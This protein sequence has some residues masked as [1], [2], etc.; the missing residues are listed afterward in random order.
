MK[1]LIAVISAGILLGG[2]HVF[3]GDKNGPLEVR[4]PAVADVVKKLP[5]LELPEVRVPPPSRDDVIA[6]YQRVYGSVPDARENQAVGKRLADLEMQVGEDRD[7]A[8]E[9]APYQAAIQLYEELLEQPNGQDVDQIIYQLARAYDVVGDN[10]S[11]KKYLDRLITQYPESAYAVESRF[12]RA[13]MAFS[14]EQY[15]T[16]AEDYSFVVEHGA[17][18]SY[19]QNANYM[20][21][22]CRFKESQLDLSLD[23][24]F[25]VVNSITPDDAEPDR[26]AQELLDDVLRVIVLAVSYLD[27]PKTLADHMDQLNKPV[28]QHRVYERLAD[29]LKAKE[30]YLDSVATLETFIVNNSLDRRA[31]VFNKRVIDTLIAADFPSEVRSRKEDFVTRY[32]VRSSFWT[33]YSDA[34]RADYLPTLKEYLGELSKL[35]H[36]EAQKSHASG[37]YLKAADYYE[38]L[39][40]TFPTDPGVA[41]NLFLLGEVYTEAGEPARAVAAYQRVVHEHPTYERANEAGYAAILG[42]DEVLKGLGP[43]DR[44]L[45]QR[46]KIDA[47]IEFAMLFPDDPRAAP[48][49]TAAADT[50]FSLAQYQQA[51]DLADHL[52]RTRPDLDPSLSRTAYVIL[53]HGAFELGQ[54]VSAERSYRSL[55]AIPG[56]NRTDVA[57]INEKLLAAIYKQGE[58]AEQSG[59][60]DEA[61]R[62]YMRIAAVAPGSELAAKG[63]NDAIAVV[64]GQGNWKEAADLLQDFRSKYPDSP[65]GADATKRLAGL[66]EKSES[67]N[68]A[69]GE[70]R[71][72]AGADGDTEV[73][74][75][76]LY[77]AGELYLQ[78]NDV[79]GAMEAFGTYAD[80]YRQ[81]ADL[82][83]EAMQKMD[84]LSQRAAD[85]STR[86]VWLRKKIELVDTMGNAAPNRSKYLAAEAQLVLADDERAAFDAVQLGDPLATSLKRKQQALKDAI[87]AYEQAAHYGV[88][89]FATASTYQIADIYAALSRQLMASTRPQG[90]SEMELE[91]Y[92]VLLEE[93]AFPFEEQ[94]I[95]IHEINVR[96]SWDGLY[97]QWVQ[98]SFEAL[99]A[100]VPARFDKQEMQVGY[101]DTIR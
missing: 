37:D 23:S 20:L 24:F 40:A 83:L 71:R 69:A 96:R 22:W 43:D 81:P 3:G 61:V 74:R 51:M 21:G 94:A 75:Q 60:T 27:G 76:A 63:H 54:Y 57:A 16:A 26:G 66:Y 14:A 25:V 79:P 19:W 86:R 56:G 2:C 8:G 44:E 84:E 58:A 92:D 6:A 77:H 82:A 28:W 29:D 7:A 97:D 10:V 88:A 41:D 90:L 65:Y 73:R 5:N 46:V 47:Q 62:N 18:T 85:S 48:V 35:S 87:T 91:Q 50:L 89:E 15:A 42:L 67:W 100:L 59:A 70:Y 33:L 45:W 38:Q 39:V 80:T 31:P 49:E 11:A 68:Q 12:R 64:E 4:G 99:R 78:T 30:R 101:V 72:V 98:K 13:E 9:E 55:L 34:E 17:S 95:S 52:I 93:Q 1:G 36:S 53:G 32:G